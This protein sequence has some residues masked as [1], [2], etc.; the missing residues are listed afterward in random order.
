LFEEGEIEDAALGEEFTNEILPLGLI[1]IK[2]GDVP[3][4]RGLQAFHRKNLQYFLK[5]QG[6]VNH[7]GQP[8]IKHANRSDARNIQLTSLLKRIRSRA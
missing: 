3:V 1:C 8:L 7:V 2:D 6:L 4:L 5:A